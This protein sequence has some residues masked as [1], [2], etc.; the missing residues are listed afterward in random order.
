MTRRLIDAARPPLALA[1]L[2]LPPRSGAVLFSVP[3]LLALALLA[4]PLLAV[5]SASLAQQVVRCRGR[6]RQVIYANS[7]CPAGTR[8]V[9]TIEPPQSP[10]DS[11]RKTAQAR[12]QS[13]A[14]ELGRE[15]PEGLGRYLVPKDPCASTGSA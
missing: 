14:R 6:R 13:E 10:S 7:A 12:A 9:R 2:A 1:S 8:A 15:K 3:R 4:L 5:S 11:D